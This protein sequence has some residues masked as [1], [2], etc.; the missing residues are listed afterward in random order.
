MTIR[1]GIYLNIEDCSWIEHNDGK[2]SVI[3][4]YNAN[5]NY[6]LHDA[7]DRALEEVISEALQKNFSIKANYNQKEHPVNPIKYLKDF[8]IST[9]FRFILTHPELD[10]M[11]GIEDL[12]DSFIILN[13]WDTE[14]NR[15]IIDFEGKKS[16]EN[17]WNYYKYLRNSKYESPKRLTLYSGV[18][19]Q[20]YNVDEN[21][22]PG[23][24]GIKILA[25]TKELIAEANDSKD[26]ND[27]SYVLL[28]LSSG[29]KVI[30][31]G[32]SHDK[33]WDYILEN[34]E[35]QVKD[36]DILIAPHHGRK[37][38]R[39]YEFLDVLKP[40][41]TYFGN[42][43]SQDLAYNAW[44]YRGLYYITNNQA[45]CI[46]SEITDNKVEIFV[47]NENFAVEFP[48]YNYSEKYKAYHILTIE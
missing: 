24:N 3:D 6:M 40:K 20:Y 39:K 43:R 25:P 16:L 23:G 33:T 8:G 7:I 47:T 15:E 9:I 29:K 27:C 18:K 1:Y 4:V 5:K 42:A 32:D 28:Y 13:F 31:A 36:I 12:F 14:N 37:S 46:I 35:Y 10:H 30:F 22:K 21:N 41:M 38:G 26:Y 48:D 11:G 45:N 44:N 34:Y 2:I 19:G 17:D